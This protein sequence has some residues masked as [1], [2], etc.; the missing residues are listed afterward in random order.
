[1]YLTI[2]DDS[3][4]GQRMGEFNYVHTLLGVDDE[5][6]VWQRNDGHVTWT[7]LAKRPDN[8]DS[9]GIIPLGPVTHCEYAHGDLRVLTW[10]FHRDGETDVEIW[11]NGHYVE[12][13]TI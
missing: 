4:A 11:Q 7:P 9:L 6:D 12:T 10:T 8:G 2:V 13:F 3:M 5:W 1:M